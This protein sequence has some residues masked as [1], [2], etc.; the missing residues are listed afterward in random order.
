MDAPVK[1]AT[2]KRIRQLQGKLSP[3]P[4]KRKPT[5]GYTHIKKLIDR[6]FTFKFT[7]T[8]SFA[9]T[10]PLS[11]AVELL[12]LFALVKIES[13]VTSAVKLLH[14]NRISYPI[15]L[16]HV[17]LIVDETN[18]S[19][20]TIEVIL[21]QNSQAKKL[22][23]VTHEDQE[24]Q[25]SAVQDVF[26]RKPNSVDYQTQ[27]RLARLYFEAARIISDTQA[28]SKIELICPLLA[29]EI[30]YDYATR[31]VAHLFD[32]TVNSC[33]KAN[34]ADWRALAKSLKH[35]V[36]YRDRIANLTDYE[37]DD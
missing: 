27:Q 18:M 9:Q 7:S 19:V 4:K 8:P 28:Y 3:I 29:H 12:C 35:Q 23:K 5:G 33:Y 10:H 25:L 34:E 11:Q 21:G 36:N 1:Q 30:L 6:A 14:E 31:P 17:I 24:K 2:N 26:I 37:F 32:A 15:L 16:E 13:V 22:E 20:D